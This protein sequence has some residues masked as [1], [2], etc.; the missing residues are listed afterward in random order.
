MDI[1]SNAFDVNADMARINKKLPAG[2]RMIRRAFLC[3]IQ[4]N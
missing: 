2:Q 1:H 3:A 4:W